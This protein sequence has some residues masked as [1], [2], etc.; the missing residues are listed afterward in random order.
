MLR[1]Y[2]TI[3]ISDN[4]SS[5]VIGMFAL[6]FSSVQGYYFNMNFHNLRRVLSFSVVFNCHLT[7]A[8]PCFH[9]LKISTRVRTSVFHALLCQV[10]RVSASAFLLPITMNL[11]FLRFY[12]NRSSHL[13]FCSLSCEHH[14]SLVMSSVLFSFYFASPNI[15]VL[16]IVLARNIHQ[17]ICLN[18]RAL[19]ASLV[20]KFFFFF[21]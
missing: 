16:K 15:G 11:V 6:L 21:R 10:A 18:V 9:L 1:H 4:V 19:W 8:P 3:G 14:F 20:D 5:H 2:S 17:P 7:F 12:S 13:Q